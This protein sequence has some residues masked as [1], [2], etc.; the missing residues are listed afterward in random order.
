MRP[1]WYCA[2]NENCHFSNTKTVE[3]KHCIHHLKRCGT[4]CKKI[5]LRDVPPMCPLFGF[6]DARRL[7]QQLNDWFVLNAGQHRKANISFHIVVV[8]RLVLTHFPGP[9]VA[10]IVINSLAVLLLR[11]VKLA[12]RKNRKDYGVLRTS[13]REW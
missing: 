5:D 7:C 10:Y 8:K 13:I 12:S 11:V 6:F 2:L 4:K 9:F 1:Q 3:N